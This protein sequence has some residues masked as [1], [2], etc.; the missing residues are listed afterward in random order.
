MRQPCPPQD[1]QRPCLQS[2]PAVRVQYIIRHSAPSYRRHHRF[3]IQSAMNALKSCNDYG[4]HLLSL[5]EDEN[6]PACN[7]VISYSRLHSSMQARLRQLEEYNKRLEVVLKKDAQ[8]S[9]LS[10]YNVAQLRNKIG[11][12]HIFQPRN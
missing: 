10:Q 2:E 3:I 4:N 5:T 6:A 7:S 8:C 11:Q 12:R 1:L 9:S